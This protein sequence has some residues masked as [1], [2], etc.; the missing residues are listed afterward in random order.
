[1]EVMTGKATAGQ[2]IQHLGQSDIIA[3]S[4]A[5]AGADTVIAE[6]GKEYKLKEAIEP[7]IGLYDYVIIDTPP[8]M[9]ILTVNALTAATG[10]IIPAQA[11]IYSL[12]GINQLYGTIQTVKKYCNPA[13]KINGILLTRYN[14][15]AIIG[16]EIAEMIEQTAG[17]LETKLYKTKIRECTAIKESQAV[18]ESIFAYAPKSNAALDYSALV[19]EI[20]KEA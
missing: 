14:G 4:P 16:R 6:T 19:N 1:M 10:C 8:A 11:D 20:L 13:L 17:Q 5:L 9:G 18:K 3:G 12:Q 15:R 2:S 7:L